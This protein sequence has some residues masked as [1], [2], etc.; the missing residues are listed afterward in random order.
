MKPNFPK[1]L[2]RPPPVIFFKNAEE[3]TMTGSSANFLSPKPNG[4]G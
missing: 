2:I 3:I 4:Q 1:D